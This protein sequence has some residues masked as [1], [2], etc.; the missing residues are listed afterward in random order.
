MR[1]RRPWTVKVFP[2]SS[3]RSA[4]FKIYASSAVQTEAG[5]WRSPRVAKWRMAKSR[6]VGLFLGAYTRWLPSK[7]VLSDDEHAN[8]RIPGESRGILFDALNLTRELSNSLSLCLPKCVTNRNRGAGK[9]TVLCQKLTEMPLD[10]TRPE[11]LCKFTPYRGPTLES[12]GFVSANAERWKRRR[13]GT[14]NSSKR[15]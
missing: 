6:G 15:S 14:A 9:I 13:E 12:V 3:R 7:R 4:S 2:L 11:N 10:I 1:A 5:Y 8:T